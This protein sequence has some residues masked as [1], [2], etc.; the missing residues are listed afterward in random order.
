[1]KKLLLLFIT[2]CSLACNAQ[3]YTV[4]IGKVN[5]GKVAML[6]QPLRLDAENMMGMNYVPK[7]GDNEYPTLTLT[8]SDFYNRMVGENTIGYIKFLY[9]Q[10]LTSEGELCFSASPEKQTLVTEQQGDSMYVSVLAMLPQIDLYK[11]KMQL[12]KKNLSWA[13][14]IKKILRK[15]KV[16]S[17]DV[18]GIVIYS[19]NSDNPL[20][21]TRDKDVKFSIRVDPHLNLA[22]IF[23]KLFTEGDKTLQKK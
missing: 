20:K 23:D 22:S 8:F 16:Y 1:M 6:D 18:K 7:I 10:V 21:N 4:S 19:T 9:F 5:Y 12:A 11:G 2:L 17:I 13:N 3:E 14:K 15:C